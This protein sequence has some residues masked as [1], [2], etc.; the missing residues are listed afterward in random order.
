LDTGIRDELEGVSWTDPWYFDL[1]G[2][3]QELAREVSEEHSLFGVAAVAVARRSD[4]DDVLFVLP[5]HDP[6]L[7]VVHLTWSRESSGRWPSTRFYSSVRQFV[8]ER[9]EPDHIEWLG[10]ESEESS[11]PPATP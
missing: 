8:S 10:P 9:M 2:L 7:A 6:L 3:E 5:T 4:N 11:T 1:S